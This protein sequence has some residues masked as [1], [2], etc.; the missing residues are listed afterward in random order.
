MEGMLSQELVELQKY[1]LVEV[2]SR[3]TVDKWAK[4]LVIQLLEISHGQRL[5]RN[6]N[7]HDR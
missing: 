5:Y 6:V 3:L 7:V 2:E 4:K 1:T